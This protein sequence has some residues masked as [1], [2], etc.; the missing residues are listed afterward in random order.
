MTESHLL[1]HEA[2]NEVTVI[3][4]NSQLKWQYKI[5]GKEI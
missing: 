5:P 1:K 4:T 2:E 3:E